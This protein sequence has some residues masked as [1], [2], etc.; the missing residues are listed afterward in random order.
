MPSSRL[1]L[2]WAESVTRPSRP[3]A[4]AREGEHTGHGRQQLGRRHAGEALAGAL[5][6]ADPGHFWLQPKHLTQVPEDAEEEDEEDKGVQSRIA[7]E[8]DAQLGDQ[9]DPDGEHGRQEDKHPDQIGSRPCHR[10]SGPLR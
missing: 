7:G 2:A 10:G 4:S 8:E 5:V 9:K 3:T 1:R 6:V